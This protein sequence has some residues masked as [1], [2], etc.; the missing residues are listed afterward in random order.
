MRGEMIVDALQDRVIAEDRVIP[1]GRTVRVSV[2]CVEQG[3]EGT[4][5][6]HTNH[7]MAEYALREAIARMQEQIWAMV[8][9]IN[10]RLGLVAPTKTYRA[11]A[12]ILQTSR[13]ARG[14]A[15]G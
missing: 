4:L 12:S 15:I 14:A 11:A 6:F 2:R 5:A 8:P 13:T 9:E 7:L 1:A 10:Q 3:R